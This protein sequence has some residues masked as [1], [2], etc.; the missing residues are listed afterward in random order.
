MSPRVYSVKRTLTNAALSGYGS[1]SWSFLAT[2]DGTP[3][4]VIHFA[5]N[6]QTQNFKLA[7]GC[8]AAQRRGNATVAAQLTV[9]TSKRVHATRRQPMPVRELGLRLVWAIA[10]AVAASN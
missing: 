7:L 6:A 3:L 9:R 5:V 2:L 1:A 4:S 10:F 8:R